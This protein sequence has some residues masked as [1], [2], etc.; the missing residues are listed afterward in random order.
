MKAY[1]LDIVFRGSSQKISRRVLVP[2]ELTFSQLAFVLNISLGWEKETDFSF[3]LPSK[4]IIVTELQ[5]GKLPNER[6]QEASDAQLY[7]YLA[8]DRSF[9]YL[10]AN[11]HEMI[12]DITLDEVIDPWGGRKPHVLDWAGACTAAAAL[13]KAPPAENASEYDEEDVNSMVHHR[14]PPLR[15]PQAGGN[16][17]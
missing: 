10:Y 9:C 13:A 14:S 11:R 17:R 16:L 15:T 8:D 12:F 5:P 2:E 3:L 4:K 6:L 7:T 1:V